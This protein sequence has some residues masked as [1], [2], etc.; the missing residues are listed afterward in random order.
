M[1]DTASFQHLVCPACLAINRIAAGRPAE[2]ANCGACH[3]PLFGGPPPNVGAAAL[4]K[5]LSKGDLPVL[6]DLWASWCGPCRQMG[7]QFERAARLLEPRV[8]L[9]KV[10]VDEEPDLSA[11]LRVQSIP[12]LVL[13]RGGQPIAHQSGLMSADQIAGWAGA[14]LS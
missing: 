9:L 6:L 10:N 11:R 1:M 8:R 14:S 3:R 2:A 5:H 13:F 7:P 12:T 4:Q